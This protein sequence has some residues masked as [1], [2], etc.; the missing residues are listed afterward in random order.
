MQGK[1]QA[2]VVKEVLI[3]GLSLILIVG[4][5]FVIF[6]EY[7]GPKVSSYSERE[8][9]ELL[10]EHIDY[11]ISSRC[12]SL[13][14]GS[15]GSVAYRFNMPDKLT[16]S[17]YRIRGN[18]SNIFIRISEGGSI[19]SKD[20]FLEGNYS[21]TYLSSGRINLKCERRDGSLSVVFSNLEEVDLE[22]ESEE[23][24]EAKKSGETISSY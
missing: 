12:N 5:T 21:G 24:S 4:G 2:L 20:S 19:Y 1:G 7:I 13:L 18:G 16:G 11:M 9:S 14:L 8:Q 22:E 23:V 15:R 10:I 3:F 6:N 17:R